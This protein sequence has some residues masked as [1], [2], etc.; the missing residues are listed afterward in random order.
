MFFIMKSAPVRPSVFPKK[1]VKAT[2]PAIWKP[3]ASVEPRDHEIAAQCNVSPVIA[4]IL[5]TRGLHSPAEIEEFLRPDARSLR[6]PFGLPDMEAAVDRLQL[7][8]EGRQPILIFGD[9]DVDGVTSTALLVR[10]LKALKAN[11]EW[12]IPEREDGYGLSVQAVETAAEQ[13]I[14]LIISADCGITS[15]EPAARARELG[16]DLIITDH[17]EPA[18]EDGRELLPGA[19]AVVNP[20]RADSRYGFRELSGCGVAF[21]LLQALLLKYAP[22]HSESFQNRYIDLVGLS[23][24]ADCV[25]LL[26]ENRYLTQL[27]LR[28]LATSKKLGV[29]ALIEASGL[30]I[31][32]GT[33]SGRNVGFVLAPRLNAAGRVASPERALQLLLSSDAHECKELA[34][35]LEE[36]NR[37]RQEW[38]T[39]V[40]HEA[41]TRVYKTVD[42]ENE[43]IL[44]IAGTDWPHGIIGLAASRLVERF[45]R[46][47]IILSVGSED[48]TA[49]GS[50][51]S[52]ADFDLTKLLEHTKHLLEGGG[53]HQAACGLSLKAENIEAFQA[54]ASEL[55]SQLLTPEQLAPVVAPDCEVFGEELTPQLVD[56]LALLEPCG[57]E[58]PEATLL[59]RNAE[60]ID[61]KAIGKESVHLKWH[62]QVGG[63]KIEALWWSPGERA[64]G[65][66]VGQTVDLCVVPE[67]NIWNN[68][69]KV[70]L[71]IKA[72]RRSR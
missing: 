4:A 7:A 28:A 36:L 27:G 46:P 32:N 65:F 2:A 11:V 34:Q 60:I 51:R 29:Q 56:D 5:R 45:C 16:I 66:A 31:Q 19:V 26:D 37:E 23:T 10:T 68:I 64:D 53:G 49:K 33:L 39:R 12:A 17:H 30:K 50:G 18:R 69:E 55:A 3:A 61:G 43:R 6:D 35:E 42:L 20:K 57:I 21:K 40:I 54:A 58:N 47:A 13:G 71:I 8:I 41:I 62:L 70:Q 15:F 24:V 22:Q 48:G 44:V 52:Y 38:T 59:V 14:E 9:Y 25:P 72:A 67:L 1:T 63:R